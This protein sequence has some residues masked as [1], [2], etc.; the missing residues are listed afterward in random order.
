MNKKS[1]AV[2]LVAVAGL[3]SVTSAKSPEKGRD[4]MLRVIDAATS[5]SVAQVTSPQSLAELSTPNPIYS[6]GSFLVLDTAQS[7]DLRRV[8]SDP[9]SYDGGSGCIFRPGYVVRFATRTSTMDVLLCFRCK[10]YAV[11]VGSKKTQVGGFES[12]AT[13]MKE[14]LAKLPLQKPG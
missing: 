9:A 2:F 7:T 6:Y 12:S 10:D 8:M 11:Y 4:A 1:I 5:I 3:I 13:Q 14:L